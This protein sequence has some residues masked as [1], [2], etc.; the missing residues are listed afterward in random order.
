MVKVALI[1]IV[2][3]L[4][5]M[6]LQRDGDPDFSFVE[7]SAGANITSPRRD[8][9]LRDAAECR[10]PYAVRIG[11]I[12]REFQM[13]R[14]GLERA[15]RDAFGVWEAY[16][17]VPLFRVTDQ[18]SA[19]PVHLRFD[20]RQARS[21][22]M[23]D[24]QRAQ[25]DIA[26]EIHR[27]RIELEQLRRD[28]ERKRAELQSEADRYANAVRSYEQWVAAFNRSSS[29]SQAEQRRLST[30]RETLERE[31]RRIEAL[32]RQHR[33]EQE[34]FNQQVEVFNREVARLQDRASAAAAVAA[35]HGPV[36]AG[37][38]TRTAA[39]ESIEVYLVTSYPDLVLTLAHELGHALGIGHV[40]N[41]QSI[42]SAVNIGLS[43]GRLAALMLSR[44]DRAALEAVCSGRL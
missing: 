40:E 31:S 32:Q 28:S 43:S 35:G 14:A 36:G 29:R 41:P 11:E 27:M 7:R 20:E 6:Y 33:L 25:E 34:Q 23:A 18:A 16:A 24:E 4:L 9:A 10:I 21:D 42:M 44:E 5:W 13:D 12:D 8:A 3:A 38:Y 26:A 37:R 17:R 1:V 2:G 15:L 19:T 39:G 30:E 22:Q